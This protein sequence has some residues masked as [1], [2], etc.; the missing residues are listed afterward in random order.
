MLQRS[1]AEEAAE[2]RDKEEAEAVAKLERRNSSLAAQLRD[3]KQQASM[4]LQ[5]VAIQAQHKATPKPS[6][7][8]LAKATNNGSTMLGLELSGKAMT[9]SPQKSACE[10]ISRPVT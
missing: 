3:L 1:A 6:R 5:G 4:P 9:V 2:R 10:T 7:V 8:P